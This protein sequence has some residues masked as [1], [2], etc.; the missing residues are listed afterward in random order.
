MEA[1]LY[2]IMRRLED[3]H[4]WFVARRKIIAALLQAMDVGANN[5]ILEVG[6]G[7]GGNI[8]FLQQFG[9]VTG[10]EHDRQAAEMARERTAAPIQQGSLPRNLPELSPPYDLVCIF[11]VIEHVDEDSE[12]VAALADTLRPG[13][14]MVITVPAFNF[15]WSR[16]DDENQHK[17]RYRKRD[18]RALAEQNG[19]AID[20]ISYFNFWLFLPVA[21]IRLARK[22]F[23]YKQAWQDMQLPNRWINSTLQLVFGT[24]K[25]AMGRLSLPFGISLI[26][27]LS[28]PSDQPA[29]D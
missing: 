2:Q 5:K 25:F 7:T 14:R 23:P 27:A 4:W 26:A 15:L 18:L 17:R 16:H 21:A 29:D 19:L 9:D 22:I 8:C 24:E 3:E 28:K 10:V 11:D 13:G 20:Y 12:S 1:K 6:C